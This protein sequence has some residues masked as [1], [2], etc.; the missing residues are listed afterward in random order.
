MASEHLSGER[1]PDPGA[2]RRSIAG[3]NRG[4]APLRLVFL[5]HPGF[6]RSQSMPRFARLLSEACRARGHEVEVWTPRARAHRLWPWQRGRK[7]A[8]YVDEYLIF[9]LEVRRARRRQPADTLFVFCDQALGPWV[10]LL[11]HRPHVVHV[12]DLLA[13]R[14]A[15]GD[16][17][18][19]RTGLSGRLYQRL[20]R[21]GFRRA[22]HFISV[23][24]QTRAEL[25]R[26]GGIAAVT[27]EVIYHGLNYPFTPL[28]PAAVEQRLRAARLEPPP[29][30]YLLHVG[31]GQ[32]Y[33]NLRGVVLLYAAFARM[34]P[35]PPALWCV[36]PPP[37]AAVRAALAQV[38]PAGRVEFLGPVT[39]PTLHALYAGARALLFP[40]LAE[41]FGWPIIEAQACGCP[42]LTTDAPPMSEIAGPAAVRL[43]RLEPH[44]DVLAWAQGSARTLAELLAEAPAERDR[45]RDEALRWAARFDT[46]RAVEA[47]LGIYRHV[48]AAQGREPLGT[49][50]L[51]GGP[52]P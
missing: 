43:P 2:G 50:A 51:G 14:S 16:I 11:A 42:V 12:H 30:G 31:G 32:W 4:A 22:R 45:R 9:P 37:G 46:E 3:D 47:Y 29:G 48:L 13:L 40:S 1:A 36:S 34:Q 19:H 6:K 23:S 10:P 39:A 27:S 21:R 52:V 28:A 20:I 26:F 7:W 17:P 25:H 33:K 15:L 41:G 44:A 38:P 35:G 18:E 24:R 5:C 8:G 49:P